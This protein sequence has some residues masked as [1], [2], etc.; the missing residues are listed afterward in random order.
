VKIDI[1]AETLK[2]DAAAYI[3]EQFGTRGMLDSE[4]ANILLPFAEPG[5]TRELIILFMCGFAMRVVETALVLAE[6]E[7]GRG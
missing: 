4:T 5:P 2:R 3:A 6:M 7:R 1:T